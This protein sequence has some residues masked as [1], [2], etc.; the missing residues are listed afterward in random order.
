MNCLAF[1][2]FIDWFSSSSFW[3]T[4]GSLRFYRN[5]P[6]H[7]E[8]EAHGSFV[9]RNGCV[10]PYFDYQGRWRRGWRVGE[11]RGDQSLLG[12]QGPVVQLRCV[13]EKVMGGLVWAMW[14]QS[15]LSTRGW[16]LAGVGVGAAS[17]WGLGRAFI[18]ARGKDGSLGTSCWGRHD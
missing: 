10:W 18:G 15:G 1:S 11:A 12:P 7:I 13:A 3:F 14:E 2:K 8:I 5:L 17:S 16:W 6:G 4:N 9:Q